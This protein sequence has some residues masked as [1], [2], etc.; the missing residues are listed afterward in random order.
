MN[1][2]FKNKPILILMGISILLVFFV[3]IFSFLLFLNK[4]TEQKVF[5]TPTPFASLSEAVE[6]NKYSPIQK[7][8]IGSA[9]QLENS[10][11]LEDINELP[12]GSVQYLFTSPII[13]RKNEVITQNETAIF[14]RVVLPDNPS[15]PG[16]A[17]FSEYE[18]LFGEPQQRIIG[19]K[20]YGPFRTTAIYADKGFALIGNANTDEVFEIHVFRPMSV[21]SYI[22]SYGEDIDETNGHE[23]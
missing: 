13:A 10:P 4:P 1:Q 17:R 9:D 12:N 21:E 5:P 18:E 20:Y 14:E 11:D 23:F 16:F 19:S 22:S 6:N 7:S 8:T 3:F 2:M 15:I